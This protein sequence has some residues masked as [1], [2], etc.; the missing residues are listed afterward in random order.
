MLGFG[1]RNHPQPLGRLTP[2]D[3]AH[4]QRHRLFTA[5]PGQVERVLALPWWHWTH[6]QGSEGACVGH[7]TAMER[8]IREGIERR[9]RGQRP[10]TVRFNP[11]WFWDRAK[12]IDEWAETNPGDS[13]GTSVRAAYD[14]VRSLGGVRWTPTAWNRSYA[15][16]DAERDNTPDREFAVTANLWATTVDEMRACLLREQPVTIGVNWYSAFDSPARVGS[17]YYVPDRS[18]GSVR[19]GHCLCVYGASDRRQAFRVKN[20]WGNSYPLVWFP[21]GL[22]Q[23]LLDEDGEATV[24]SDL[25]L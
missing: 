8:A 13:D 24:V 2:T 20:S 18:L 9:K 22:M 25:D 5:T 19:G 1:R 3:E 4:I 23:R 10:Y 7:G 12:E 14:I 17:S 16:A 6:D 11:W 15:G 21:Y